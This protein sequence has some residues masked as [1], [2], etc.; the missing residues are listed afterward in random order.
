MNSK[1]T[2]WSCSLEA[3]ID[4]RDAGKVAPHETQCVDNPH[5]SG[6]GSCSQTADVGT[7][8]GLV[9]EPVNHV[10]GKSVKKVL[11]DMEQNLLRNRKGSKTVRQKVDK[12][13]FKPQHENE[14]MKMAKKANSNVEEK[15]VVDELEGDQEKENGKESAKP[16]C[17]QEH[18]E[19]EYVDLTTRG[20]KSKL[21]IFF[22]YAIQVLATEIDAKLALG[23]I[24]HIV[25]RA[26]VMEC[27]DPSQTVHGAPLGDDSLRVSIYYAIEEKA[28]VPFPVQDEIRTVKQAM[29][30]WVAW[31]KELI[32]MSPEK[33]KKL[34]QENEDSEVQFSLQ[35]LAP[36]L[37]ASLK[38]L[39][40]WGE[41]AF[42]D[43]HTINFEM[44]SEV[45]GYVRKTYIIGT[46]VRRLA[47]MREITANCIVVYLRYLYDVLTRYKMR[48][49][50]AFVDPALIGGKGCGN[51]IVRS[52]NIKE[53]LITA[54]PGQLFMLPY[55]S[56][57]HWMLTVVD[58]DKETV[59][60]MDPM[61]RRL[62]TGEWTGI[63]DSAI[64]MYNSHKGRKGRSSVNWKNLAVCFLRVFLPNLVTRNAGYYV[65]R[66][67]RDI[68][69]DKDLS[70]ASKWERR[71]NLRYSQENIDEVR[72]EWAKFVVNTY[73]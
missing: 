61:K 63:V 65:M 35:K 6:H 45:F 23:S 18:E 27:D 3:K 49:M 66:Y 47:S 40:M 46:D 62:A 53:R 22:F 28:L 16:N 70:F 7:D 42:K 41:E 9:K 20:D 4:A 5:V 2:L 21:D 64:G 57:S 17:V 60:F 36:T 73:V 12:T 31:P 13:I 44:D 68:I 34:L 33:R 56:D 48:D 8:D 11:E 71:G 52:Q 43:G 37:P 39:C 72:N 54:K 38:M 24:D 67:I 10:D 51:G 55:N 19:I 14:V 26:T 30:S 69:E 32:I 25:A 59:Y 50:I 29:G 58:P 1:V 15:V